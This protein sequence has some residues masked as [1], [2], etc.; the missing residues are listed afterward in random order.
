MIIEIIVT[1]TI[2]AITIT[3]TNVI[4]AIIIIMAIAVG[5]T[6]QYLLFNILQ[7]IP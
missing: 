5:L 2:K 3:E 4:V 7:N 1:K 6:L